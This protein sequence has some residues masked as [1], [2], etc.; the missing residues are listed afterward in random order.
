[1]PA[2]AFNPFNPFEQ[3]ISVF[4]WARLADFGNRLVDEANIAELF[5]VGVKGDKLF[6][7]SWGYHGAFRYS[8]IQDTFELRNVSVS[9][10]NRILNAADSIF[11][12]TKPDI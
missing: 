9:R 12:P 3:I 6:N 2:D 5:T 10:F 7:G 1:M 8:Q 11:N 4:T